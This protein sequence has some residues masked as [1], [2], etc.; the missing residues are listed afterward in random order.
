MTREEQLE[1]CKTCV[2]RTFSSKSGIICKLTN[3]KATFTTTC[4]SYIAD[5]KSIAEAKHKQQ[6]KNRISP[7]FTFGLEYI[8]IKSGIV[9]G[10]IVI[11]GGI[12]W[13]IPGLLNNLL[14]FRPLVVIILGVI[15]VIISTIN[16][17]RRK[18]RESKQISDDSIIDN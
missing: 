16:H 5:N 18:K 9:A 7:D 12:I 6:F 8:G 2:N 15:A 11:L 14:N 1:F 17:F 13:L 4:S 3:E 10:F